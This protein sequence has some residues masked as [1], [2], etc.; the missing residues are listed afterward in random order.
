MQRNMIETI[1]GAVVLLVAIAFIVFAFR[2]SG[3]STPGGYRV[4]AQFDDASGL[5]VGTDVRMAGVKVGTVSS[6]RLDPETYLALVTFDIDKSIKLPSDSSARVIPDGL[7]GGNFVAIE[8]GAEE[9]LIED[10]GRIEYTQ[11]AI[12]VVDLIGRFVFNQDGGTAEK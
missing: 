3:L 5:S 1:L 11:G 7:L 9:D 12:N 6:Q 2:S 4:T 8:P 10:G